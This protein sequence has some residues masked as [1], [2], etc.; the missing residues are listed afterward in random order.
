MAGA[1]K[2]FFDSSGMN[3]RQMKDII[4]ETVAQWWNAQGSDVLARRVVRSQALIE[5]GK[6]APHGV[7]WIEDRTAKLRRDAMVYVAA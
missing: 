5:V 6:H 3:R 1:R 4:P 2:S 7:K